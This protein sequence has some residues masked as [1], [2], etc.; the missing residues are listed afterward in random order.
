[1]RALSAQ[2][3]WNGE[4]AEACYTRILASDSGTLRGSRDAREQPLASSLKLGVG[5]HLQ[6]EEARG[7]P[8]QIV[9]PSNDALAVS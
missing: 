6:R 1:M 4:R 3:E 9:R 5:L 7:I 8:S 2:A